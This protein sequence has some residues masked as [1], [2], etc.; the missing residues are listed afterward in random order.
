ML[1]AK[2]RD[3]QE[4]KEVADALDGVPLPP[5]A[6][7]VGSTTALPGP[8]RSR[9]GGTLRYVPGRLPDQEIGRLIDMSIGTGTWE[10]F[11][12]ENGGTNDPEE[13][14]DLEEAIDTAA[15]SVYA[16]AKRKRQRFRTVIEGPTV[17]VVA[18]PG[19]LE[20]V[21]AELFKLLVEMAP[22]GALVSAEARVSEDDWTIRLSASVGNRQVRATTRI[23]DSLHLRED[24]LARASRD[25]EKQGGLLWV[26]V[27][28]PDALSLCFTLR[29]PAVVGSRA[30]DTP[31]RPSPRKRA[32]LR[33]KEV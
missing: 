9:K 16:H 15:A 26:E 19:K 3:E 13:E 22:V 6:I 31:G 18:N 23:A 10:E 28:G 24:V 17:Y 30:E 8:L 20:S 21:L 1:L 29:T 25:I 12:A 11:S 32:A 5:H 33:G 7:H 14:T 2:I 4:G 27:I